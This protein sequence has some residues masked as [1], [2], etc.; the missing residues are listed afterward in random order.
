MLAAW[1]DPARFFL[2]GGRGASV[3][4]REPENEGTNL[5]TDAW[6]CGPAWVN[7][8]FSGNF[9]AVTVVVSDLLHLRGHTDADRIGLRIPVSAGIYA[10]ANT[11]H[12]AGAN[13]DFL[14]DGF[15]VLSCARAAV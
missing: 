3:F 13:L 5:R 11:G 2:L 12:H 4:Y 7:P 15:R 1:P 10:C 14:L 8:D 9:S 6:A